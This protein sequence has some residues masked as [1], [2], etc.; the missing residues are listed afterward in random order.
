MKDRIKRAP[1]LDKADERS[2]ASVWHLLVKDLG[3]RF[4]DAGHAEVDAVAECEEWL[5]HVA[6]S[7]GVIC[8]ESLGVLL[9]NTHL[10]QTLPNN[11]SSTSKNQTMCHIMCA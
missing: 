11:S 9:R 8:L 5:K 7:K 10:Q 2:F 6:E 4:V 3:V 1:H